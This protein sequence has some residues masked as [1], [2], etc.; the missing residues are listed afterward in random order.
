VKHS[1]VE[2]ECDWC[3]SSDRYRPG[4]VDQQAR[5][6]GWIVTRTG[7]HFC[8]KDCKNKFEKK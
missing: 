1:F 5:M 3:G 2:V 6:D 4:S 8:N 7:K